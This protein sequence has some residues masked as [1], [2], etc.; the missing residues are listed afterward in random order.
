M[1]S[2]LLHEIL[3]NLRTVINEEAVKA[4]IER[5]GAIGSE[6]LTYAVAFDVGV[7]K[8]TLVHQAS[9]TFQREAMNDLVD[10]VD[11]LRDMLEK[12]N[13]AAES[14]IASQTS[15]AT[16]ASSVLEQSIV[17]PDESFVG[18]LSAK[19]EDKYRGD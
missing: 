9:R 5:Y 3:Q 8:M 14:I 16:N 6:L 17:D 10:E 7:S 19:L 13:T 12:A 4:A 18:E 1:E 2:E 15:E 11:E